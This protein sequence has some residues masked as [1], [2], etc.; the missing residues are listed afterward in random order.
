MGIDPAPCRGYNPRHDKNNPKYDANVHKV[1]LQSLL[2]DDAR[3]K[4]RIRE[5]Y[6]VKDFPEPEYDWDLVNKMYSPSQ[7][8]LGLHKY[9]SDDAYPEDRPY[10]PRYDTNSAQWNCG[11]WTDWRD[12]VP[13][14]H[15]MW[16]T[17]YLYTDYIE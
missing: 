5:D 2:D 12:S 14:D 10:D 8:K 3:L 15:P 16:D 17:E 1:W 13:D 6:E 11:M 9:D 4:Y 7:I